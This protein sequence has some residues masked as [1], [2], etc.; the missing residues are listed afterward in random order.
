MFQPKILVRV[1][2]I[3]AFFLKFRFIYL[4]GR[5]FFIFASYGSD[6]LWHRYGTEMVS[7][8]YRLARVNVSDATR[9]VSVLYKVCDVNE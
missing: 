9:L 2:L 8:W 7:E 3:K 4:P 6:P 1:V 5:H